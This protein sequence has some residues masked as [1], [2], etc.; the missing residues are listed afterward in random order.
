MRASCLSHSFVTSTTRSCY[1]TKQKDKII[2]LK[3]N[4]CNR[5]WFNFKN[6]LSSKLSMF[7]LNL[8]WKHMK[9]NIFYI[10]WNTWNVFFYFLYF[11]D[12]TLWSC[13]KLHRHRCLTTSTCIRMFLLVSWL[14]FLNIPTKQYG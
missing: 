13:I 8:S 3:K 7:F 6:F 10:I 2:A 11:D 1:F 9:Y 12:N 4:S 5:P 14:K